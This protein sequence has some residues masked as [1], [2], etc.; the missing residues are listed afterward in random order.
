MPQSLFIRTLER[1]VRRAGPGRVRKINKIAILIFLLASS[2]LLAGCTALTQAFPTLPPPS[3]AQTH[4][5]IETSLAFEAIGFLNALTGDPLST[6]YYT[7]DVQRFK[8]ALSPQ[9][10]QSLDHLAEFRDNTLHSNL[11]GFYSLYFSAVHAS[12]LDDLIALCEN[13]DSIRRAL[14]QIDA[15]G[16]SAGTYYSPVEWDLFKGTLGDLR[17]ALTALRDAG[18]SMYW[19]QDVL[20]QLRTRAAALE[21]VTNRYNIIPLIER[22]LGFALPSG[23]ITIYLVEF[24]RPYGHHVAG[25]QLIT[26]PDIDDAQ[27]VRTAIHEMMHPPFDARDSRV[28]QA[29]QAI[30]D[31]AFIKRAFD[32]RDPKYGYNDWDYYVNE[33]SVRALEQLISEKVGLGRPLESRWGPAEDGGMHALSVV[34]YT[35]MKEQKFPRNGEAYGAF[36]IRMVEDGQFTAEKSRGR[37][38]AFYGGSE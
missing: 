6:P 30:G 32:T 5:N 21:T 28:L 2:A 26:Q 9:A 35:L 4:W 11:S 36:L 19:E 24:I 13:P 37:Y 27:V 3:H 15:S 17:V 16:Q 18:F 25:T 8:R 23:D 20:P 7:A 31:D 22:Y 10:L 33:D 34:L 12:S 14:L 38:D 29:I 1:A